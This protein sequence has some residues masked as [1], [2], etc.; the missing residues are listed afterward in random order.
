MIF[1]RQ[2]QL[3]EALHAASNYATLLG[4]LFMFL[5][6]IAVVVSFKSIKNNIKERN[7]AKEE[8]AAFEEEMR[9]MDKL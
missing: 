4:I 2:A 7:K 6:L 8:W 9:N 3:Q 1:L 5:T